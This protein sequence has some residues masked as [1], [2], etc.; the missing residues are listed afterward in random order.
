MLTDPNFQWWESCNNMVASWIFNTLEKTLHNS[1]T[2]VEDAKG[3]WDELKQRF[4]QGNAPRIHQIKSELSLLRQEGR[5]V[6]DYFMYLKTLWDK[7]A[8]YSVVLKCTC[9]ASTKV[10]TEKEE[11]KIH[12]F[13]ISLNHETYGMIRSQ[14]LSM[15]PLPNMNKVYSLTIQEER[16][17]TITRGRESKE[18]AMMAT[19]H[20]AS[21][22]RGRAWT[23]QHQNPQCEHWGKT[24]HTKTHCWELIGYPTNWEPRHGQQGRKSSF[25]SRKS[26]R[27]GTGDNC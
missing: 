8:E 20:A 24:G 15:E 6:T 19:F 14:I 17:R 7:L 18:E 4:S 25:S 22:G 23:D 5:S 2:F 11:A 9:A 12:Q 21:S 26:S 3:M 1:V 27:N 10:A 13:L 16:Q